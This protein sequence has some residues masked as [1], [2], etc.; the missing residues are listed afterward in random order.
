MQ[1]RR[2]RILPFVLV[3]GALA[4]A[5]SLPFLLQA[6]GGDQGIE[7]LNAD[8]G[9]SSDAT[10]VSE[11]GKLTA[12]TVEP[13]TVMLKVPLGGKV[14]QAYKAFAVVSGIKTEVTDQCAWSLAVSISTA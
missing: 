8:A 10:D 3:P 11:G 6:C 1:S 12:V 13:A 7:P 14:S 9:T 4:L 2:T 5:A